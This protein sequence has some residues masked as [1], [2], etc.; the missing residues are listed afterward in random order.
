MEKK[1]GKYKNFIFDFDGVIVDSVNVKTEAFAG[2]YKPFGR[3]IVSKVVAHHLAH[4]GIDRFRKIRHYH[5]NYLKREISESEVDALAKKFSAL[6]L[7][8]VLEAP[9]IKGAL[10]LLELLK[11]EGRR[12]FLISATPEEEIKYIVKKRRLK[13]FFTDIKGSPQRKKENLK[14]FIKRYKLNSAEILYF[15]DSKQDRDAACSLNIDF[16]PLNYFDGRCGYKNFSIW[17]KTRDINGRIKN[18]NK[19]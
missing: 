19:K 10:S 3:K 6:A 8:R 12:I 16:V 13:R 18:E 1:F 17:M 2:L 7:N 11:R 5:E 4:G 14:Y 15:G 9:F